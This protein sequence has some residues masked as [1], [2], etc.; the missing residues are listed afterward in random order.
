VDHAEVLGT[1]FSCHNG[2]V[3][4]GKPPQHLP[5][6]NQCDD[7]HNTTAWVPAVFDHTGI[8][9][10]C[11]SCHNGQLAPGKPPGHPPTSNLCEA[12][13]RTLAWVPLLRMDHGEALGDCIGCHN[14]QIAEG[15]PPSHIPTTNDCAACHSTFSWQVSPSQVDHT[16]IPLAQTQCAIC[17]QPDRPPPGNNHPQ[18]RD[19]IQCHVAPPEGGWCSQ[20]VQDLPGLCE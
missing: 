12:C 16:Q 10:G 2:S 1:C 17:H 7:C 6:S 11:V 19:C 9:S 14:G 13:H 3:A 5:T 18:G 8:V 15:Q 20:P 4:E